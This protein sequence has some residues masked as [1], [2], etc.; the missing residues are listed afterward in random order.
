MSAT[1]LTLVEFRAEKR[2]QL[3]KARMVIVRPVAQRLERQRISG[4]RLGLALGL[5][6]D[7]VH[8]ILTGQIDAPA[9]FLAR[10]EEAIE[11]IVMERQQARE[12]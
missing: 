6:R 9:G 3:E 2:R 11:Q 10:A 5:T 7:R 1:N 8:R 12:A 4:A